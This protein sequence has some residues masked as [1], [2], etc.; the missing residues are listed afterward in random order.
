MKEGSLTLD[1]LGPYTKNP[2]IVKVLNELHFVE[3]LGS[4]RR[5]LKKYA[6]LYYPDYKIEIS[7]GTQFEFS[8]TYDDLSRGKANE[9]AN[10]TE[11]QHNKEMQSQNEIAVD[12]ARASSKAN[13]NAVYNDIKSNT[14]ISLDEICKV[15][16]ISKATVSRAIAWLKENKY[17]DRTSINQYG[18]W[19]ILK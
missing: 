4:G 18:N 16:K 8:I 17:I 3:D 9:T 14:D 11:N 2:L 13:I 6:P 1:E 19:I 10:N 5:N 7:N 15:C 12:T